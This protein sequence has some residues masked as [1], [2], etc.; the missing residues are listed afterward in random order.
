MGDRVGARVGLLDEPLVPPGVGDGLVPADR[1]IAGVA[2]PD[3]HRVGAAGRDGSDRRR[4]LDRRALVVGP[5]RHA[6]SVAEVVG[7]HL[8]GKIA[9]DDRRLPVEVGDVRRGEGDGVARVG[10]RRAPREVGIEAGGVRH[11][12]RLG[13]GR[14]LHGCRQD[15]RGGASRHRCGEEKPPCALL[16]ISPLVCGAVRSAVGT[17][18]VL[19]GRREGVYPSRGNA[20]STQEQSVRRHPVL[21]YR[22]T[23]HGHCGRMHRD[24]RPSPPRDTGV[25]GAHR[26]RTGTEHEAIAAE[27]PPTMHA[28]VGSSTSWLAR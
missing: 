6:R 1:G 26:G 16:H 25:I 22:P 11:L 3:E 23:W 13:D 18:P 19:A 2:G 5:T 20:R 4:G 24:E 7:V 9:D 21:M 27:P 28:V 14:R 12:V 8:P 15:Q 10:E 17:P